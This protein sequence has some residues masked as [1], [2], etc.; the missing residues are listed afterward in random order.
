MRNKYIK[1]MTECINIVEKAALLEGSNNPYAD[2][3]QHNFFEDEDPDNDPW[4]NSH[5]NI[6]EE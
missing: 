3:K 1:P 6:W 2:G 5:Y 4:R